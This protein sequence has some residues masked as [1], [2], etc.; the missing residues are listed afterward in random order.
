M[1]P[2][3]DQQREADLARQQQQDPA[4]KSLLK[5][6]SVAQAAAVAAQAAQAAA[7]SHAA[8]SQAKPGGAEFETVINQTWKGAIQP[9]AAD[10]VKDHFANY[11][12]VFD[13][14]PPR[15][16]NAPRSNWRG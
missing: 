15:E 1:K 16:K 7:S 11:R 5:A 14:D 8:A 10:E 13:K 4:E 3:Q 2:M 12:A 6:L 9:L